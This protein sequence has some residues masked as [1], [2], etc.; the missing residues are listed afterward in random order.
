MPQDE[1]HRDGYLIS[2]DPARLDIDAIHAYLS[3]SYWA[4]GIPRSIVERSIQGSL[5]FGLFSGA[6]QVGFARII[7]D[8]ATFAYLCDV[9]VLEAHRG[10]GLGKWLIEEVMAHPDIK[11]VRRFMLAT[12]D[13]HGLYARHGFAPATRP[14]TLM[15]ISIPGLY[16]RADFLAR[17][18]R[19]E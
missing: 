3:R 1:R 12:R 6:E 18:A 9:Y 4:K 8:R 5:C 19:A 17:I 13:A 2:T 7:S 14:E 16:E 11:D 10:G 15:E